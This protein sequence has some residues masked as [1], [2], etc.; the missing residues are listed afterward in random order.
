[1]ATDNQASS[2]YKKVVDT[3]AAG[4]SDIRARIR[5][6]AIPILIML[7]RGEFNDDE[8]WNEHSEI[9]RAIKS[10]QASGSEGTIVATLKTMTDEQ[11]SEIASR[12]VR[13]SFILCEKRSRE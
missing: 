13:L 10:E 2:Q 9:M 4:R 7:R 8:G 5:D 12:L 11:C 6:A 3:L 1:M